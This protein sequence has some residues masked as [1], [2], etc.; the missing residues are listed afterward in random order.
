[1]DQAPW[2]D[3][4]PTQVALT[5]INYARAQLDI[6]DRDGALE[7][8]SIAWSVAPQMD[9]IHPMGREVFRVVSS[10]HLR[11]N[12]KLMKHPKLSGIAS[13]LSTYPERLGVR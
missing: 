5:H 9:R 6:G 13:S 3:L 8:L 12:A 1:M 10:L 11:G 4:P 2:L 7:S